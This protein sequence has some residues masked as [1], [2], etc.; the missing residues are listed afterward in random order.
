MDCLSKNISR[1]FT[2]NMILARHYMN[3]NITYTCYR[4]KTN[5]SVVPHAKG[6]YRGAEV[7]YHT[8]VHSTPLRDK[9]S[10]SFSSTRTFRYLRHPSNKN[11]TGWRHYV[12]MFTE[13]FVLS[14]EW[15]LIPQLVVIYFIHC[16]SP[17]I[18]SKNNFQYCFHDIFLKIEEQMKSCQQ[19]LP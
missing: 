11:L 9:H 13:E 19:Y 6:V 7:I 2:L 14:G 12:Y 8:N 4:L 15:T 17:S 3:V 10:A 16:S 18:Y 5:L 1:F